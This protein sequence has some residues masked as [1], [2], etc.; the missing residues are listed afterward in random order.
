MTADGWN[1]DPMLLGTPGGTVDL[2]TG[3]LRESRREDGITKTTS[4][5]PLDEPCPRWIQFLN[6]AT[7]NDADLIR[8]LQQWC[9]Y[10]LTGLTREHA[11]VFVYG[12]GGNGKSRLSQR[13]PDDHEGLRSHGGDG[14]V[15]GIEHGQAPDRPCHASRRA[16]GHGVRNRRRP[17]RGQRRASSR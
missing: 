6:E 2:R 13:G 10:G 9:G 7:G 3:E 14:H 15:H 1:S 5:A 17:C 8:F 12:S 11:L 16:S 4:V